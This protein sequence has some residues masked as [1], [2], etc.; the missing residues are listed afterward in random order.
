LLGHLIILYL[1]EYL[2]SDFTVY[3]IYWHDSMV[4]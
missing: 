3:N 2:L 4:I 1:V